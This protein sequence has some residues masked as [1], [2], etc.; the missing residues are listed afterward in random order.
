M[1]YNLYEM[2]QLN[3]YKN[4]WLLLNDSLKKI[5]FKI[6]EE[7][8]NSL[9]IPLL[10]SYSNSDIFDYLELLKSFL[11]TANKE[12]NKNIDSL[13]VYIEKIVED[14]L[15]ISKENLYSDVKILE[16]KINVDF[17][18]QTEKPKKIVKEDKEFFSGI[19]LKFQKNKDFYAQYIL[20][21]FYDIKRNINFSDTIINK[22]L[23]KIFQDLIK[24]LDQIYK[25]IDVLF[26]NIQNIV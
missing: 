1:K 11:N 2:E 24:Q 5:E 13:H 15:G 22:Y 25:I 12:I 14:V 18:N 17:Y 23:E 20:S 10:T 9:L 26:K 7:L 4:F 21:E 8:S 6:N 16:F 3:K 19:N